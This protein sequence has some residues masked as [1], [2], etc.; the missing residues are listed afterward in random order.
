VAEQ[1]RHNGQSG[2]EREAALCN[3]CQAPLVIV[4][5]WPTRRVWLRC[6]GGCGDWELHEA[7]ARA[8]FEF[9]EAEDDDA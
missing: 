6:S 9:K 4:K 2:S 1:D 3:T 8:Y 5:H 7:V